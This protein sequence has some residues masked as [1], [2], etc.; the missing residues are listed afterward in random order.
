MRARSRLLPPED[1]GPTISLSRPGGN[2]P[3]RPSIPS[4][5]HPGGGEDSIGIAMP[6]SLYR[7]LGL[8]TRHLFSILQQQNTVGPSEGALPDTLPAATPPGARPD[9]P[10]P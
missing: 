9:R 4:R 1:R 2:R 6:R 8:I 10:P 3:S 7:C 5:S